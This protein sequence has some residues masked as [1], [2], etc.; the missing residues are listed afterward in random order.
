M[1][2]VSPQD[3]HCHA[4]LPGWRGRRLQ[5]LRQ[6]THAAAPSAEPAQGA[7]C[8]VALAVPQVGGHRLLALPLAAMIPCIHGSQWQW[9]MAHNGTVAAA[10]WALMSPCGNWMFKAWE[11][12]GPL[13]PAVAVPRHTLQNHDPACCY[14]NTHAHFIAHSTLCAA[15]GPRC[16]LPAAHIVNYMVQPH[17][18]TTI[19][20][21]FILTPKHIPIF[22]HPRVPGVIQL[23]HKEETQD[24]VLL[25]FRACGGGDLYRSMKFNA[26]SEERLRDQVR[27]LRTGL[28]R[29][30]CFWRPTCLSLGRGG[31]AWWHALAF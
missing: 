1:R 20:P 26:W 17:G 6:A 25:F 21:A 11:A 9:S 13:Q 16:R 8:P 4:L 28:G 29:E 3:E 24:A 15:Q 12:C 27:C 31:C 5:S 18:T 10:I 19:M 22:V 2:C 23:L 14:L 30:G 7:S